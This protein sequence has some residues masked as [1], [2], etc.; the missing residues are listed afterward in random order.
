MC[1]FNDKLTKLPTSPLPSLIKVI[2]AQGN[3]T[4][5]IISAYPLKKRRKK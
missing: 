2:T 5:V 1:P 4:L 3:K